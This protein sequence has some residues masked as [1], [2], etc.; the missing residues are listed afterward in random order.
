MVLSLTKLERWEE[1]WAMPI[2]FAKCKHIQVGCK[3]IV[4]CYTF[5]ADDLQSVDTERDLG[6]TVIENIDPNRQSLYIYQMY[7]IRCSF[8]SL[9]RGPQ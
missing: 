1:N 8:D 5:G 9:H 6:V 3:D 7:A 4:T 2:N